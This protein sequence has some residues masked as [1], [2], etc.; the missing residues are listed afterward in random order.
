MNMERVGV[1][2]TSIRE[3]KK[4]EFELDL[5]KVYCIHVWNCPRMYKDY[6]LKK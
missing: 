5:I 3:G 6:F 1:A 2:M 4:G